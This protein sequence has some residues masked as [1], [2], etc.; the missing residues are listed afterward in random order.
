MSF[1]LQNV[2]IVKYLYCQM[3]YVVMNL[4][5]KNQTCDLEEKTIGIARLA[6]QAFNTGDISKVH[7]FVS[8]EYINRVSRGFAGINDTSNISSQFRDIIKY[9]S[10]LKG[11]DEFIDTIKYLRNAFADLHYEVHEIVASKDKA[12]M[13]VTVSGKHV[14]NFFG[15]PPTGRSFTYEAVHAFRIMDNKIVEHSA[16]RDD[17]SFMMQLGLVRSANEEYESLFQAW[18]GSKSQ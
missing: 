8:P 2:Y 14:G 16:V 11:P 7:E 9:R 13:F 4:Q 3:Y 1:A 10:S 15:I 12:I 5:Q 17:L 18:K 6:S